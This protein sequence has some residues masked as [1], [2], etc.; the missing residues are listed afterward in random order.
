MDSIL[1]VMNSSIF[2]PN[3]QIRD[4]KTSQM[5]YKDVHFP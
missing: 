4:A 1:V 5:Y 2:I 3:L